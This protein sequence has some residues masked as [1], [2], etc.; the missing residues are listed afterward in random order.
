MCLR[1]AAAPAHLF[2]DA[3]EAGIAL[4]PHD[5]V[6]TDVVLHRSSPR[7]G[8]KRKLSASCPPRFHRPELEEIPTGDELQASKR[9]AVC[10]AG[11]CD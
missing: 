4:L 9:A 8:L 10:A 5:P 6:E 2:E 1:R 3:D 7:V 11:L